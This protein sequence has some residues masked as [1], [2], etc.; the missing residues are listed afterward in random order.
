M[1]LKYCESFLQGLCFHDF[2]FEYYFHAAIRCQF[3]RHNCDDRIAPMSPGTFVI[4]HRIGMIM[5]DV[6]FVLHMNFGLIFLGYLRTGTRVNMYYIDTCVNNN[7]N[8]Y[9]YSA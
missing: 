8:I 9:L 5:W 1:L 4:V 7:N 2:Y 3:I 6:Y